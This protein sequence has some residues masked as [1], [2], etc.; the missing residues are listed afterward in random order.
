M[1]TARGSFEVS[2]SLDETGTLIGADTQQSTVNGEITFDNLRISTPGTF[3]V[4]A[5]STDLTQGSS[6]SITLTTY[7]SSITLSSVPTSPTADFP[8]VLTASLLTEETDAYTGSCTVTA[9]ESSSCLTGDTEK[10][11]S[12]GSAIMTLYC[13]SVGEKTIT[14]SCPAITGF[15]AVNEDIILTIQQMKL[16]ITETNPTV[17]FI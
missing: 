9:S 12:S 10:A 3:V 1:L 17:K 2:L 13:N 16:K 15:P 11:A 8:F 6:P 5:S 4:Q 7:V 14:V